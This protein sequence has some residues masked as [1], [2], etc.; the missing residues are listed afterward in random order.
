M[1]NS[2]PNDPAALAAAI[3]SAE[4][5]KDLNE[6]DR[7]HKEYRRL[8]GDDALMMARHGKVVFEMGDKARAATITR[9]AQRSAPDNAVITAQ[10]AD[11]YFDQG[12]LAEA[13]KEFRAA[14][15][16]D[17][18]NVLA[19]RRLA[20]IIQVSPEGRAEAL[21]LLEKVLELAPNDVAGWM[22]KGAIFANDAADYA[23]AEAAFQK[24]LEISPDTPSALHN[25]G[26]LRRFQGDVQTARPYLEKACQLA[27]QEADFAF[28]LA[29]CYLFMED[30]EAALKWFERAAAIKPSHNAAH[31]YA[32]YSLLLLGRMDEGWKRYEYRL[33]LDVLRDAN[34]QRPRWD[35]NP[36]DGQ[37]LL[38]LSEQGM[39]DNIQFIRYAELAAARDCR[40]IV[41][42]HEPLLR[43]YKSL[44]GVSLVMNSIP[45]AKHFYRYV[46]V[47][48]LPMAFGTTKDTVPG[49][50]PYLRAPDDLIADW[51][52]RLA[53]YPGLKVGLCWRG[54]SKHVNDRFRS[55]S[56]KDISQLMDIPGITFFSLHKVRPEHEQA[57]PDGM[58]DIGS[59]FT[60]FADTAA[61][62][63][64]LDLVISVDT[65]VCHLA[66]AV[67]RPTWTMIPRGPD[68]RWGINSETTPWYPSMKLYR[69]AVLGD[70]SDV[71]ARMRE[72]LSA[73]VAGAI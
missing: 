19:L 10:L 40:V 61:A 55:T 44:K 14:L 60:D 22:Q 24:A 2:D 32:A 37:T 9:R 64:N 20:Q 36:L 57:L 12:R 26:L 68:F 42:A 38:I 30:V 34:Y 62:A 41:M 43:L 47:M 45:E 3:S 6:A 69:Q 25:Y 54:N 70:W 72:D 5:A 18:E 8:V 23:K 17:P 58:I 16:Q 1:A 50:V 56:L 39:G 11:I 35:G 59:D 51:K 49:N 27:P 33:K 28:S 63:E 73:M 21:T 13:E 29:S 71:Y 53:P 4:A 66:G 67:G 15:E 31:V 52:D 46:P 7:L 48:S 65:S